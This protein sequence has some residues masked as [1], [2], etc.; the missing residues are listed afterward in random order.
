MIIDF[1][2]NQLIGIKLFEEAA[3]SNYP[4]ALG[5]IASFYERGYSPFKKDLKKSLDLRIRAAETKDSLA[6]YN[7]G[8]IYT[9]GKITE[10]N[11]NK[12][13]DLYKQAAAGGHPGALMNLGV[14]YFKFPNFQNY[15][16]SY[17]W[18]KLLSQWKPNNEF[19][20]LVG[21]LEQ[22]PQIGNLMLKELEKKLSKEEILEV[23]DMI[24][25]CTEVE[26]SEC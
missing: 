6:L 1:E 10:Q 3:E 7:L 26:F 9:E 23:K 22:L 21:E 4:D 17:M 19:A 2:K 5:M 8:V 12:A 16:K 13:T 18:F 11:L 15:K 14:L 20:G 25:S 24:K